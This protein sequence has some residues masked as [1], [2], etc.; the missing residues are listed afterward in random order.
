MQAWFPL[1]GH[2]SVRREPTRKPT[3]RHSHVNMPLRWHYSHRVFFPF[4][5]LLVQ[6][7]KQNI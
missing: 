4:A 5:N 7:T 6:A 3:Q 2:I 1:A